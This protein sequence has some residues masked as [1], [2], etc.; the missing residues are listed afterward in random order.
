[1]MLFFLLDDHRVAIPS[2]VELI[3]FLGHD[4][5]AGG[6]GNELELY[7]FSCSLLALCLR[8]EGFTQLPRPFIGVMT[9]LYFL[10]HA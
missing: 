1:M 8:N 10:S 3:L 9:S 4:P 2:L 5:A 7:Y 6:S